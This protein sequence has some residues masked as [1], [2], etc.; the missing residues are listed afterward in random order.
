MIEARSLTKR[1]GDKVAVDHLSFSVEP[2][3]ITGFL[4][5]NVAGKPNFGNR[6][7]FTAAG[8]SS[9]RSSS[10]VM[11]MM[12]KMLRKVPLGKSWPA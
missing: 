9:F 4:G 12:A 3:K 2:G 7:F 1:Y 6:H 8:H 5:P 10:A 11:P